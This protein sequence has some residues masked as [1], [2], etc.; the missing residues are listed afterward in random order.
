[1]KMANYSHLICH[2]FVV[3]ILCLSYILAGYFF[4]FSC[5]IDKKAN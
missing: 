1:M 5:Q 4:C 3:K 2:F